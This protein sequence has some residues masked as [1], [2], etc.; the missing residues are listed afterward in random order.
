VHPAG[1]QL[2]QGQVFHA[3]GPSEGG[4]TIPSS[5][6]SI[7]KRPPVS[8]DH[9]LAHFEVTD[10]DAVVADVESGGAAFRDY[11][12]GPL[13]TMGHIATLGLARAAWFTDPDGNDLGLR[14]G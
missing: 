11:T 14:Q 7:F 13:T 10:I 2:P 6:I 1:G 3:A 12:E 9:T 8:A 4:W 5:E